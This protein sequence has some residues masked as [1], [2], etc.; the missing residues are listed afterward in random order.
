MAAQSHTS[1]PH[2]D[3]TEEAWHPNQRRPAS[4]IPYPRSCRDEHGCGPVA[5][6]A[7]VYRHA[8]KGVY[9][10]ACS[11]A[12]GHVE[13]RHISTRALDMPSAMPMHVR[14]I[15]AGRGRSTMLWRPAVMVRR[16]WTQSNAAVVHRPQIFIDVF[17]CLQMFVDI[18]RY[19]G[20]IDDAMVFE[21]LAAVPGRCGLHLTVIA[22][23]IYVITV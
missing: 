12:Y 14:I 2:T 6:G 8:N 19:V 20:R 1:R 23:N 21:A 5:T 16:R 7:A 15:V 9:I 22:P 10:H 4:P 13:Y 18:Y 11:K 17:R 3:I